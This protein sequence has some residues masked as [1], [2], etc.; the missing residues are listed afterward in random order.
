MDIQVQELIDKIRQD[1]IESASNKAAGIREN[2]ETE[3]KKILAAAKKEAEGL[4]AKGKLE[5]EK[6]QNAANAALEQAGRN[7]L[8]ALRSQIDLLFKTLL[9]DKVSATMDDAFLAKLIS[10]L[11]NQFVE[12]NGEMPEVLLDEARLAGVESLVKHSLAGKLM[13]K[14]LTLRPVKGLDAGFRLALKDGG[15]WWDFSAEALGELISTY[16]NPQLAEN[17]ARAFKDS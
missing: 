6:Y 17:V 8:L 15:L 7:L 10:D 13:E 1:G 2:A 14:G 5:A 16:L 4:I 3:A 9:V 12:N 11:C